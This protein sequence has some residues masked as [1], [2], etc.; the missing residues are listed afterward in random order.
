MKEAG[1]TKVK[2]AYADA[3]D[4]ILKGKQVTVTRIEK[5]Y[6]VGLM[7][8]EQM[9]FLEFDGL[10]VKPN[11]GGNGHKIKEKKRF[12]LFDLRLFSFFIW[13]ELLAMVFW[14][15]IIALMGFR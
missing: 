2:L 10:D 12:A 8:R 7:N 1:F 6:F 13:E 9:H 11:T 15:E 5:G 4:N 14:E 3:L